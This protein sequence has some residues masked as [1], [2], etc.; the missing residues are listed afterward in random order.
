[1]L[2]QD[3]LQKLIHQIDA[4]LTKTTLGRLIVYTGDCAFLEVEDS[5][6]IIILDDTYKIEVLND[7]E[8]VS[9]TYEQAVH[10]LSSDGWPLYAGLTARI[11]KEVR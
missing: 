11:R 8:W 2:T 6:E 7:T 1:M 4:I 3:S 10:T 5:D 9:I